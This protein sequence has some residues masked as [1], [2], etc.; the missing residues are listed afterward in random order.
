MFGKTVNE[1]IGVNE[2]VELYPESFDLKITAS[3]HT[4]V[5]CIR[6]ANEDFGRHIVPRDKETLSRRGVLT[7]VAD[8]MGGHSSGE[9]ASQLAVELIGRYYYQDLENSAS[10]ALRSSIERANSEVF[11]TSAADENLYGMGTTVIA[12]VL[13]DK[14][15]FS[16]HVGDSRLYRLRNQ[17]LELLTMDHSQVMEMVQ[18]GVLKYEDAWNHE[19]KNI[20]L[21]AL[22][23][24]PLVD[25]EMSENFTIAVGDEFLLCSDGLSDL[26]HDNAI[27]E[28]WRSSKDVHSACERLISEAKI[29]GGH[30]NITVGIVGISAENASFKTAAPRT[31]EIEGLGL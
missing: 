5:G 7:I 14:T 29:E 24:Q 9:V 26:L 3:V 2:T 13:L 19:D 4:D 11:Q 6:D 10:D 17:K 31:R 30:D 8:G 27:G 22:G 20:I 18:A 28:I 23:T 21:R 15:A 12:L 16:A 25:V 1:N